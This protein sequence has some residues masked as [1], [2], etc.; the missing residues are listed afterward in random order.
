MR[1]SIS[2]SLGN[3]QVN[4]NVWL[5]ILFLLMQTLLNELGYWQL[6]RAKEKKQR[7]VQL[8]SSA[9]QL[10][11][12]F[13][14]ITSEDLKQFMP[15]KFEA[16]LSDDNTYLI[17]N[18]IQN[19]ELGYHV[20][21]LVTE[22]STGKKVFVNRGWVSA[23]ANRKNLPKVTNPPFDWLV[24]GRI[25]PLNQDILSAKAEIEQYDQV[26]RLP[27]MDVHVFKKLEEKLGETIEPFIIRLDKNQNSGFNIDW[28]WISMKPEKHL[29]YA[30]QWFAL[31]FTLLIVSIV[32]ATKRKTS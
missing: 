9:N 6:D 4:I 27:V 14:K 22:K 31:A 30:F 12:D 21:N 3:Y 19:G 13:S 32:A 18:K 16:F 26:Y 20:L 25:Y 17:E 28:Q 10:L 23:K 8:D 2:Y 5:F 29:A 7:M 1:H 15:I 11:T 24:L